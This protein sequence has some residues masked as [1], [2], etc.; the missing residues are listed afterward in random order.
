V[1]GYHLNLVDG[2][3]DLISNL[4]VFDVLQHHYL[5]F[6]VEGTLYSFSHNR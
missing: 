4:I 3:R 5:S 2:I 1:P 6:P